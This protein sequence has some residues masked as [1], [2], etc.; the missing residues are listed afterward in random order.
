MPDK[1]PYDT[2]DLTGRAPLVWP[3][4][5]QLQ[6]DGDDAFRRQVIIFGFARRWE[7]SIP[8]SRWRSVPVG[9]DHAR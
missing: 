6:R 5:W 8:V 2:T 4:W 7:F 3:G 1:T 9:W